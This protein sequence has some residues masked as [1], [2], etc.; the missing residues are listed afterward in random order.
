MESEF[1][2][3][4]NFV[5][6]EKLKDKDKVGLYECWRCHVTIMQAGMEWTSTFDYRNSSPI[7]T[8]TIYE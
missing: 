2:D 8:A 3:E 7:G 6:K 4:K 5:D 1:A